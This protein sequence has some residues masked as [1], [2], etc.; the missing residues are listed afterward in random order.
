MAVAALDKNALSWAVAQKQL[1]KNITNRRNRGY[2]ANFGWNKKYHFKR[3]YGIDKIDR[4]A[5]ALSGQ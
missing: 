4:I 5:L 1:N 2:I 3:L